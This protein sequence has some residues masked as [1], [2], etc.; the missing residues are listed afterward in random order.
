ME[1]LNES[2]CLIY[3][4]LGSTQ[5]LCASY[6]KIGEP[7]HVNGC[8]LSQRY[9]GEISSLLEC[10]D[11]QKKEEEISFTQEKALEPLRHDK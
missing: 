5:I 2:F 4:V 7:E 1:Q 6:S 9:V 11:R 8:K 10:A 3:L